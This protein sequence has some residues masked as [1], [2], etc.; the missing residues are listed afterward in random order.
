MADELDSTGDNNKAVIVLAKNK[1]SLC[2]SLYYSL[3]DHHRVTRREEE[4]DHLFGIIL[5]QSRRLKALKAGNT[6]GD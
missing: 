3:L 6:S 4:E 1:R 5:D 2:N